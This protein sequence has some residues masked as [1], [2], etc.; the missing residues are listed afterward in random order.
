M[1]FSPVKLTLD[2]ARFK[3][4]NPHSQDHNFTAPR[5]RFP[6]LQPLGFIYDMGSPEQAKSGCKD[7]PNSIWIGI[8][9]AIAIAVAVGI[10]T[11]G[12]Q[13]RSPKTDRDRD[14]DTEPDPEKTWI[15]YVHN[16]ASASGDPGG[17]SGVQLLHVKRC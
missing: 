17:K 16:A 9:I 5:F 10:E 11:V 14:P 13:P 15:F 12:P 3:E 4:V 8:A 2:P 7:P 6:I 1:P